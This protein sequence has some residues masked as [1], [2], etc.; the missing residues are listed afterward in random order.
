MSRKNR[1]GR[2]RVRRSWKCCG[3]EGF[4]NWIEA[5]IRRSDVEAFYQEPMRVYRCERGRY[6][7]TTKN[8]N[9]KGA[10]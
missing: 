8:P 4:P 2:P 10:R 9:R 6:H 3:K 7:L 1:R 5:E